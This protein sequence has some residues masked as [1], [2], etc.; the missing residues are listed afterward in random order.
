[1]PT[2]HDPRVAA[3]PWLQDQAGLSV[4]GAQKW[5][6]DSGISTF[7]GGGRFHYARVSGLEGILASK[8][9]HYET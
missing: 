8:E 9:H 4:Y 6:R 5:L 7:V 2:E 1:M 3:V